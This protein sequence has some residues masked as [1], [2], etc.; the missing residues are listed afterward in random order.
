M[1]I[2]QH[3]TSKGSIVLLAGL[4]LGVLWQEYVCN[5]RVQST[6]EKA[7]DDLCHNEWAVSTWHDKYIENL[8]GTETFSSIIPALAL[9]LEQTDS[10]AF[11][12]SRGLALQF[13]DVAQTTQ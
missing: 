2:V 4:A 1:Q 12:S 6:L 10:C 5:R 8:D 7:L 13:S 3:L 9:A 11:N